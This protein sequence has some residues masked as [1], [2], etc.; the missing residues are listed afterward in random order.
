MNIYGASEESCQS[1]K[2]MGHVS[3]HWAAPDLGLGPVS[4]PISSSFRFSGTPSEYVFV[5]YLLGAS[6]QMVVR[7]R[8]P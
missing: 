6:F 4:Y 3:L 5:M 7:V 1:G 8:G 2:H